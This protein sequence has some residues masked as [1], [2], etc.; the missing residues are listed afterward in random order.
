MARSKTAVSFGPIANSTTLVTGNKVRL[1]GKR[2][3]AGHFDYLVA[4]LLHKPVPTR[5]L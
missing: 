3:V 1:P 4:Q 5:I 2:K